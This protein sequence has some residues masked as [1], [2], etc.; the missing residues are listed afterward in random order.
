MINTLLAFRII[1]ALEM[2]S[3]LLIQH[4]SREP[5]IKSFALER[6]LFIPVLIGYYYITNFLFQ[7][8]IKYNIRYLIPL[9]ILLQW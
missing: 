7:T 5:L 8:K 9:Y 4:C 6:F 3:L 2:A 1:K